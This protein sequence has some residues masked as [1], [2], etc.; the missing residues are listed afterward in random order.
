MIA[1]DGGGQADGHGVLWF[2]VTWIRLESEHGKAEK[3][4]G[5]KMNTRDVGSKGPE[6]AVLRETRPEKLYCDGWLAGEL[7]STIVC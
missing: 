7:R 1:S 4:R 2:V 3:S 5:E 6:R